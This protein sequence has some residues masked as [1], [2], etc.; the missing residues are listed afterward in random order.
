M[1]FEDFMDLHI[2][3]VSHGVLISLK[4]NILRHVSK[5]LIDYGCNVVGSTFEGIYVDV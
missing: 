1:S 5:I 2:A 4:E 3:R